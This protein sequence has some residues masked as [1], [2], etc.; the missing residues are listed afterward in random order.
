MANIGP[1]IATARL[2]FL[3]L[4]PACMVLGLATAIASGHDVSIAD[5]VVALLG[6][7]AAHAAVNA[8]NE[9]FDFRSG[10]DLRTER[11]PFSGGSGAL[12][13]HPALARATLAF[14][15]LCLV[16][17]CGVGLH[18]L[19]LRGLALLPIGLAG[20]AV[21]LAYTPWVTRQPAA[22]LVAPGLGVGPLMV[23]GTHVALTGSHAPR[24][25]VASL[26]PFFLANGLLLLNQFPDVE[27]DRSVGRRHLPMLLGRPR[28]A[29]LHAALLAL[30]YLSLLGGIATGTLPAWSTL[31][32]LTAPLAVAV[33]IGARR[34]A[35]DIPGL[36]PTMGLNV[37][38]VLLTPVLTAVGIL[39]A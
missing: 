4:T 3:A 30:A 26:V 16:F 1:L 31:G 7:L 29:Q 15:S 23:V 33:A 9:Y 19:R 28:A 22:S 24:A 39:L 18:F 36:Q 32:L 5:G 34:H 25:W 21:V 13:A 38:V 20:V 6:G 17:A 27:A 10:L 35:D 11:T 14:A 2:P 12:P 37:V 8:F